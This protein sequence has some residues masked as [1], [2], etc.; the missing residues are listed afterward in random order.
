LNSNINSLY[1]S[2]NTF[3]SRP[4][5]FKLNPVLHVFLSFF[6][7]LYNIV[8]SSSPFY[9]ANIY[10][11]KYHQNFFLQFYIKIWQVDF[12]I[13]HLRQKTRSEPRMCSSE[14]G[15]D[16]F[17]CNH[18]QCAFA[19]NSLARD[20]DQKFTSLAGDLGPSS[21]LQQR[22]LVLQAKANKTD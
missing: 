18:R 17:A 1:L 14:V 19:S 6:F 5:C 2:L 4:L 22:H 8:R 10:V 16:C 20:S 15:I 12:H 11:T 13:C 3:S 7:S 9:K 21:S